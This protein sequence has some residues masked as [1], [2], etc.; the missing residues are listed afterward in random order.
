MPLFEGTRRVLVHKPL[1][2]IPLERG[3]LT[4]I[5][6]VIVIFS[7]TPKPYSKYLRPLY[8]H[9]KAV[10]TGPLLEAHFLIIHEALSKPLSYT[11]Q[12]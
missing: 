11:L 1:H 5:S 7:H 6:V 10:E 12:P 3:F 4:I 9:L 8:L 2:L